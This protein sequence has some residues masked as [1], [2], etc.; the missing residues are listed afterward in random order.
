MA[1]SIK[2]AQSVAVSSFD[3]NEKG[4]DAL[5]DLRQFIRFGLGYNEVDRL[6]IGKQY[7]LLLIYC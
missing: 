3:G 1:V 2:P 7:R 5:V 6:E 4:R